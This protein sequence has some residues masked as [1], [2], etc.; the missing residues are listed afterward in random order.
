MHRPSVLLRRR[1]NSVCED[2]VRRLRRPTARDAR[3]IGAVP[4]GRRGLPGMG[5]HRLR[6]ASA[7]SRSAL[8]VRSEKPAGRLVG[9]IVA[10][11]PPSASPSSSSV[12]RRW[13]TASQAL[14]AD[15]SVR[16]RGGSGASPRA[17][18][19]PSL[20][21][22]S[23]RGA[24]HDTREEYNGPMFEFPTAI[25]RAREGREIVSWSVVAAGVGLATFGAWPRRRRPS[26]TASL[27]SAR[28]AR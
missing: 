5:H 6:S 20:S 21:G 23:G 11:V 9:T 2:I 27:P 16:R 7:S 19:A 13:P 22:C 24:I 4:S 10:C 8:T 14:R 12:S 25:F 26:A 18:G 1:S 15:G 17:S 28:V 3:R